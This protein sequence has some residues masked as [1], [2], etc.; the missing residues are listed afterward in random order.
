MHQRADLSHFLSEASDFCFAFF[1]GVVRSHSNVE[2]RDNIR[3]KTAVH[4]PNMCSDYDYL[5][6][7]IVITLCMMPTSLFRY[8]KIDRSSISNTNNTNAWVKCV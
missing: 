5:V 2:L 8:F 4:C 6:Y 3:N 1:S 7:L